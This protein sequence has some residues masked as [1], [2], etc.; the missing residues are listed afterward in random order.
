MGLSLALF[1]IT[2]LTH[3]P[4]HALALTTSLKLSSW[5]LE[6]NTKQYN[7]WKQ[8]T[9][10]PKRFLNVGQEYK[11][12][13]DWLWIHNTYMQ[14]WEEF[15]NQNFH[16]LQ[17]WNDLLED[18][19]VRKGSSFYWNEIKHLHCVLSNFTFEL[20]WIMLN[21][22]NCSKKFALYIC[23]FVQATN[24]IYHGHGVGSCLWCL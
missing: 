6:T 12:I 5:Q 3:F 10:Q 4:C 22:K 24:C 2:F 13:E 14:L 16:F 19:W 7:D 18:L 11:C 17:L 23:N 21:Q 20:L 15:T 8:K 1:Y 9:K